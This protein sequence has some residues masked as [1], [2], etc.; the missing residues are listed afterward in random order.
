MN[1]TIIQN[2]PLFVSLA[3]VALGLCV[4][5]KIFLSSQSSSREKRKE[6]AFSRQLDTKGLPLL[7]E[8][9]RRPNGGCPYA[10]GANR[11]ARR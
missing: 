11:R 6:W 9:F 8:D 3:V 10:G 5:F 2:L 7:D 4:A 1:D